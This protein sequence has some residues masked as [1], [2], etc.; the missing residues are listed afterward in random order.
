MPVLKASSATQTAKDAVVLDLADIAQQGEA[1][2][3]GAREQAARIIAEA[4]AER[5]RLIS[6]A[7]NVGHREGHAQGLAEG[8]EA[9]KAAGE[10]AARAEHA[11]ELRSLQASWSAALEEFLA[12]RDH[13]LVTCKTDVLRLALSIAER[14]TRRTFACDELVIT[15]QIESALELVGK[16]SRVMIL[17]HPVQLDVAK[18]A[19]PDLVGRL[20]AV[21]HADIVADETLAEDACVVRTSDGGLIHASIETQLT[22]IAE[23]IVPGSSTQLDVTREAA[24]RDDDAEQGDIAA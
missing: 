1:I 2:L 24:P 6:D 4:Q 16:P 23:L 20:D 11:E 12:N 17:V 19:L 22:R 8:R 14:I 7:S 21:E 18:Q 5:E 10:I 3:R 15:E 13:L 9:G